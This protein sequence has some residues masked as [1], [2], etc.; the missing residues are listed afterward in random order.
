M[1][2]SY[3]ASKHSTESVTWSSLW[4]VC[5]TYDMPSDLRH[6]ASLHVCAS[7][8]PQGFL[9]VRNGERKQV[10]VHL[11]TSPNNTSTSVN[12]HPAVYDLDNRYVKQEGGVTSYTSHRHIQN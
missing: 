11:Y 3:L 7:K 5:D 2:Y 9:F 10:Y 6:D 4:F 12:Y 1:N 8:V